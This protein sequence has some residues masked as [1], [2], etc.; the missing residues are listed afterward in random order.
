MENLDKVLIVRFLHYLGMAMWIGGVLSGLV[1]A[2][3]G[4][5]EPAQVRAPLLEMFARLHTTVIVPGALLTGASGVLWSMALAGGQGTESR[6][7]PLGL[8]IMS[9][10]GFL[11]VLLI[12]FVALPAAVRLGILAV[13]TE[14][15]HMLPEF[16]R[17][18]KR[19]LGASIASGVLAA[20]S[21]FASVLAP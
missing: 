11:G 13:P 1:L 17:Q 4:G 8:W 6:V 21:L 3:R 18:R 14:D 16:E 19:L 7:A 15:G 12:A 2:A 10:A 9:G 5:K 20:V